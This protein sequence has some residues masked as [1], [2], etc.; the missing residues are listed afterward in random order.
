[1]APGSYSPEG[2]FS[3]FEGSS[4]NGV[5]TLTITDNLAIDNGFICAWGITMNVV[6]EEEEVIVDSLV[7][8]I[9]SYG[10]YCEEEPSSIVTFDS[11]TVVV[12]P[13]SPGIHTCLLYTSPSPRDS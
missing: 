6:G 11:T 2:D 10:W 7:P 1:M 5:W 3:D 13:T 12:Q 9:L 4:A 8:E